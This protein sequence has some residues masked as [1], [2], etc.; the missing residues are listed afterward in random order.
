MQNNILGLDIES[1]IKIDVKPNHSSNKIELPKEVNI[2]TDSA[3]EVVGVHIVNG[4]EVS[5]QHTSVNI[6]TN[7][8]VNTLIGFKSEIKI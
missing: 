1:L 2:E 4:G 6:K 8:N 7:G 5:G 3:E